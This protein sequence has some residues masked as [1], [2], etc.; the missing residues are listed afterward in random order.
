MGVCICYQISFALMMTGLPDAFNPLSSM[1]YAQQTLV[2]IYLS[3]LLVYPIACAKNVQFLSPVSFVALVCLALG[4]LV[5]VIFGYEK[6]Y[7]IEQETHEGIF[8]WPSWPASISDGSSYM[9]IALYCYGLCV[10]CFPIEE[11]MK[12]KRE[13][14]KALIY[15]CV[16]VTLFYSFVGDVLSAIYQFDP[17]GVS[18]NILQ[19]L[20]DESHAAAAV[21]CVMAM[22]SE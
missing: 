20:P 9:G 10:I 2:Y 6:V 14:P 16:F 17:N 18:Q 4:L 3:A 19:N 13:F 7:S 21:R 8:Q 1:A 15:S 22:V 5:L 11:S 12:N